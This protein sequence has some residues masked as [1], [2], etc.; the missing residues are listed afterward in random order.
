MWAGKRLR[1]TGGAARDPDVVDEASARFACATLRLRKHSAIVFPDVQPR[2]PALLLATALLR[3]VV[4][5]RE[6]KLTPKP[7]VYFGSEIGIREQLHEVQVVGGARVNLADVFTAHHLRR[8]AA[9]GDGGG[10]ASGGLPHVVTAYAPIDPVGLINSVRPG[11][12][13]IDVGDAGELNWL[14]T[15]LS[16]C[17]ATGIPFVAWGRNPFS[18]TVTNTLS[19]VCTLLWPYKTANTAPPNSVLQAVQPSQRTLNPLVLDGS[20]PDALSKRLGDAARQ[21][22]QVQSRSTDRLL[23]DT[24]RIS[25]QWLRSLESLPV[26]TDLYEVEA[27]RTWGLKS[28]ARMEALTGS[29]VDA[30]RKTYPNESVKIANAYAE[31]SA[32]TQWVRENDPPLWTALCNLCIDP[33][34]PEGGRQFV[35][36]VQSRMRL[37]ELALLARLNISREDLSHVGASITSLR[38]LRQGDPFEKLTAPNQGTRRRPLV[39]G[40]PGPK[41]AHT[42]GC[43]LEYDTLDFLLL[44]HQV[45][46]F[47][48]RSSGWEQTLAPE[49]GRTLGT[50]ATFAKKPPHIPAISKPGA[51]FI[52]ATAT[53]LEVTTLKRKMPTA[54]T[55][56]LSLGTAV[57]EAGALFDVASDDDADVLVVEDRDERSGPTESVS[58]DIWCDAAVDIQCVDGWR[59]RFASDDL[60]NLV[61]AGPSG[62]HSERRYAKS[63][64]I[65]DRLLLIHGSRR[66]SL[67]DLILERVHRHPSIELHLGLLRRWRE[68]L[69]DGI[70]RWEPR[71]LDDLLR[72]LKRRGST[73]TSTA[74][75]YFWWRGWTLCPQNPEDIKRT[76]DILGMNTVIVHHV[77]VARAANRIRGLH[78]SLSF[79]LTRFLAESQGN[80]SQLADDVIDPELGLTFNDFSQ[81]ISVANV[82]KVTEIPGPCLRSE[83]GFV[84][85]EPR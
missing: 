59:V 14:P 30:A 42:L 33:E 72:E 85:Q 63:I 56:L 28:L 53:A 29:F 16:H 54:I 26:P 70:R 75:L 15:L 83:L 48:R 23:L 40:I 11:W 36:A 60:V 13:A 9:A 47:V 38:D 84:T 27:D 66:Q 50:L 43:L 35:F 82:I 71:T 24:L 74:A 8:N 65:G 2:R 76:A 58:V 22:A 62:S 79:R 7:V 17:R 32:A 55:P 31:L 64:R 68:E 20:G 57:D 41:W 39:I 19:G 25:W 69:L 52:V 49:L 45:S 67:Y 3:Y 61:V 6:W 21:L 37:F 12:V 78:R 34:V 5:V 44:P 73:L 80:V 77:A 46:G 18:A 51:S 10:E 1:F 4:D 81:S